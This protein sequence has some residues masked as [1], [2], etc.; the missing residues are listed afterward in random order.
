MYPPVNM[1]VNPTGALK[2]DE[3]GTSDVAWSSRMRFCPDRCINLEGIFVL[4]GIVVP[5][6]VLIPKTIFGPIGVLILKGVSNSKGKW[7]QRAFST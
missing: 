5:T 3:G 4:K 2:L 1:Y 7:T 6:G